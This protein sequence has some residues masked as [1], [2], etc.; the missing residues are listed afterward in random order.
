M[1]ERT[2]IEPSVASVLNIDIPVYEMS[3]NTDHSQ[4]VELPLPLGEFVEAHE[5]EQR[6]V[7]GLLNLAETFDINRVFK[8]LSVPKEHQT[9]VQSCTIKG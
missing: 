2:E 6:C 9:N 1:A 7:H 3:S 8:V 5:F 4:F